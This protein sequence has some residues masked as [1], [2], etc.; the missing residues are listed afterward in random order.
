[1]ISVIRSDI[2]TAIHII[3]EAA[4]MKLTKHAVVENIQSELEFQKNESIEAV[5]SLLELIK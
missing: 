4:T 3:N 2:F 1:M 5:E